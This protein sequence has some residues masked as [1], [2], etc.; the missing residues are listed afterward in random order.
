MEP[1]RQFTVIT[2]HGEDRKVR[3]RRFADYDSAK[4]HA[5]ANNPDTDGTMVPNVDEKFAQHK[6]YE[7]GFFSDGVNR[8]A[9]MHNKGADQYAW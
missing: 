6:E 7:R 1:G 2:Q 9:V 3:R 5:E 4:A 8:Y